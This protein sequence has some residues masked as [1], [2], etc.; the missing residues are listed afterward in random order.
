ML[1]TLDAIT[2]QRQRI[3]GHNLQR[4]IVGD[5]HRTALAMC[6]G[7]EPEALENVPFD[8]LGKT[9]EFEHH[10]D[11]LLRK[12]GYRCIHVDIPADLVSM[13][14]QDPLK[15]G[16]TLIDS[17]ADFYGVDAT[18]V[19]WVL[20]GVSFKGNGH[21]VAVYNG[22]VFDPA[23]SSPGTSTLTSP[24]PFGG[25]VATLFIKR[26]DYV[27]KEYAPI[28]VNI[29]D[30]FAEDDCGEE[31]ATHAYVESK[32]LSS[33]Q[34]KHVLQLMRLLIDTKV[35]KPIET[36]IVWVDT[37][38]NADLTQCLFHIIRWELRIKGLTHAELER[39]LPE[40]NQPRLQ[41]YGRD[42]NVYS[43]S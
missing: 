18:K 21:S 17:M 43:E 1:Q 10:F 6:L 24:F 36:E 31:Q 32:G 5:C 8:V 13:Y 34:E 12:Q 42:L 37:S 11:V 2:F 16:Q 40:L 41:I 29:W 20:G 7:L 15:A 33:S 19:P 28:C 14:N 3:T 38:D 27:K 9:G 39:I 25:Y 30:D 4:R 22:E 26:V 35:S 23:L